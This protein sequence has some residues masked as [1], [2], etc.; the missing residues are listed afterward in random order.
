MQ[1]VSFSVTNYRSITACSRIALHD[2]TVLVGKNN[3]GKSNFLRALNV[4]MSAI[5]Y[6]GKS[7]AKYASFVRRGIYDWNRDFPVQ[8]QERSTSFD[9]IFKLEFKLNESELNEFHDLTGIH[10]NEIIPIS[11][12]IGKDN[13]PRLD[14]PKKGSSAYKEQS[15]KITDFISKRISFNYI[16]AVR[17]E[18][19]AKEALVEA[20]YSELKTLENNHEYIEAQNRINKL[21][22]DVLDNIAIKL[23]GPLKAFLPE[24]ISV[25]I[26]KERWRGVNSIR[27]INDI[28][29]I[30]ND[31]QATSI[32]DKGDG[33]K[34]LVTLAILQDR[35]NTGGT[36]VIAIEEPESH[37]HSGAIHSLL[38]VINNMTSNNQVILTTHNPLFVSRNKISSNIIV[39][40]GT[41]RPA[42]SITEIR[43]LLGVLPSDNLQN[44]RFVL[45]VE[46]EDD[47]IALNKILPLLSDIIKNA[48]KN[49]VLVI[50]PLL[51]AS[52]L[53]HDLLDLQTN[54]CQYVVLLDYDKAGMEAAEKAQ[55]KGYLK[56][57][58]LKYTVTHGQPQAEF[59]DCIK[60]SVY[61][62]R[63]ENEFGVSLSVKEFKNNSK[64][65]DRLKDVFTSQGSIWNDSIEKQAK[66]IVANCISE[67][68]DDIES[69]LIKQKST[70]LN[71]LVKI[72]ED[73]LAS[74]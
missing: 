23:V 5:I 51:G 43:D 72:T 63:I 57:N 32:N 56:V 24:L 73:M 6:H 50:K 39:D 47:K 35:N 46:G 62:E 64:W 17:T 31:G 14:V 34:S 18:G 2:L 20:I 26:E 58:Q 13:N 8:F 45:V 69:I 29:V 30:I 16:K 49:N 3:E 9:S 37:L 12:R 27:L 22:Q 53:S 38:E 59:E 21:E 28:D 66:L 54:M 71:G 4:A 48:I 33:I 52:N 10:G 1:I 36:S 60:P 44:A 65:S 61:K 70:F 7:P 25:A 19:M 15:S 11:V 42:K 55:A 41:V 40:S 67:S 68:D 74:E